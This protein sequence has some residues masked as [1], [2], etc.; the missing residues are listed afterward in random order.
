[1][2]GRSD[3]LWLRVYHVLLWLYPRA[4]RRQFGADMQDCFRDLRKQARGRG[5]RAEI[6]FV[7]R[8]LGDLPRS[9]LKAHI[10]RFRRRKTP[11]RPDHT[12][13]SNFNRRNGLGMES[14][15][16]D[17]RF[18]CAVFANTPASPS[19]R[20]CRLHLALAPTRQ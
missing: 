17:I 10:E 8:T 9:A 3:R 11:L 20:C 14:V 18:H 12:H 1:M 2:T 16:H 5:R 19:S 15:L 13:R 7:L 6:S 4:V